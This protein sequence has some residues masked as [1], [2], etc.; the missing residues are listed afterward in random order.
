[1]HTRDYV[2]GDVNESNVLVADDALVTLVDTDS[3]QVRALH[4]GLVY[5][6]PVGKP[7]FT[8]PELQGRNFASI[9]R[10][11]E[12]DWFGLAVLIFQLLMEGTHPFAGRFQGR[13]DPPPY[14]ER[15][16]AGH[17]PYGQ[18]PVPYAPAA[19]ALPFDVLH[20][21]VQHLF[22]R[23]FDDGHSAPQARPD[24]LTW[25]NTL[26][27]ARDA[28]TTCTSNAQHRYGSHLQACPWCERTA[29]LGGRDPFP[30]QEA[31]RRRDHLRPVTPARVQAPPRAAPPRPAPAPPPPTTPQPQR[32]PRRSPAW[33]RWVALLLLAAV[34]GW[35]WV[36]S[37]PPTGVPAPTSS[38]MDF[39]L[40]PAGTFRMGSDSGAS[41][42]KPVHEVRISK[43]F[44]LGKYEVTQQ[45]W[46]AIMGTNPSRFKDDPRLP[47]ENVSWNDV[48][49]F[50]QKLNAKEGGTR[51]RLPTEAEWE[52]AARAGT[53]TAYSFGNDAGQLGEYAWYGANS[54]SKTHLVGQKK[55]NAW[56]LY[57]MHGNVWE[58]VE[59]WYGPYTAGA[60]VDPAGPSSG[61]YRVHR[62]G[63]WLY[64]ARNCRSADRGNGAPGGR[65]GGLGFRLLRT[66]E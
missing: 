44:Y 59:D 35:W 17:F 34:G 2:I 1:L 45:E 15:I 37:R 63:S 41:D 65:D 48:Q 51:Y 12:H 14:E 55:P 54:G 46:Q 60:A 64:F 26:D 23:C 25:R 50:I 31:V 29:R 43:P 7:E 19:N 13:G 27:A 16:A 40:I 20:P 6:C 61:S 42:E 57:D 52:Y 39:M 9:D 30:S 5:R 58:W 32:P 4:N 21:T 38:S 36:Q 47:V 11:S 28:L 3:F 62:G 56:G 8:P 66:A 10:T 22:L 24:A 18:R 33:G 53:T 49:E